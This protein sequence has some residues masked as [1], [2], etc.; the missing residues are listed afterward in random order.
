M[1]NPSSARPGAVRHTS[2]RTCIGCRQV[3]NKRELIRVVRT[4]PGN[5]EVDDTGKK[6]GRG[7]YLHPARGC[8]EQALKDKQLERA[9]KG[10][11]DPESRERLLDYINRLPE[12][13]N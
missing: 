7:A 11:L 2:Q 3:L 8:W 9:L 5:I 6:A 1:K 4:P 10:R 13:A 12:G